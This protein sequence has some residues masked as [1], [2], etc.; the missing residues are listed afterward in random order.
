MCCDS[1]LSEELI[2]FLRLS[3]FPLC[4]ELWGLQA[5]GALTVTFHTSSVLLVHIKQTRSNMVISDL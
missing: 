4:K 2:N 1:D 3:S 5:G